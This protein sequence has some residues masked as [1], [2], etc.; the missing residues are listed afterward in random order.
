M[1]YHGPGQLVAY[2]VLDLRRFRA[3]LHW[4]L[5]ALEEVVIRRGPCCI[6][7]GR[8]QPLCECSVG[9]HQAQ[10]LLCILSD[11]CQPLCARNVGPFPDCAC[12]GSTTGVSVKYPMY[13]LIRTG[14]EWACVAETASP[15]RGDWLCAVPARA[16]TGCKVQSP[17]GCARHLM[18]PT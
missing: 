10:P 2:P 13:I 4:Y 15:A 5:R 3:D 18:T 8:C 16:C 14:L 7:S 11:R 9:R 6:P 12:H 1:T 17:L